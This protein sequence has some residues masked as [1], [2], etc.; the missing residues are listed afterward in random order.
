MGAKWRCCATTDNLDGDV[1]RTHHAKVSIGLPIFNGGETIDRSITSILSQ[2]YTDFELIISDNNSEDGTED[3]CREFARID[4]RIVYI[5]HAAHM[6]GMENYKHVLETAAGGYFMWQAC[7]DYRSMNYLEENYRNLV[8][9]SD[10]IGSASPNCF[11]GQ[12]NDPDLW[13]RFSLEGS[14]YVRIRKFMDNGFRSHGIFYGLFRRAALQMVTW[15]VRQPLGVDWGVIATTLLEGSIA[16]IDRG[17]FVSG[18]GGISEAPGRISRFQYTMLDKCFP[19]QRYARWVLRALVRSDQM[20]FIEK[21][22]IA[23]E[24]LWLNWRYKFRSD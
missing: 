8:G 7:D 4:S 19:F 3:L 20:T 10:C 5:R 11:D 2:T 13:V 24:L 9:R 6:S 14:T 18:R 23:R 17:L 15:P 1:S 22:V 21:T 12:E 16:R